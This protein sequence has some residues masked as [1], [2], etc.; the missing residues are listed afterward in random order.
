MEILGQFSAEIN[1][2]RDW[3]GKVIRSGVISIFL[4]SSSQSTG[5]VEAPSSRNTNDSDT[6]FEG[7]YGPLRI[8]DRIEAA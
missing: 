2:I 6:P 3:Q 8:P 5:T 1:N 7:G 4:V